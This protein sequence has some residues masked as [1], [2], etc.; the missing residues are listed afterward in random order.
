MVMIVVEDDQ[1]ESVLSAI[2]EAAF[3]NN[4]GDGKI[5]VTEVETAYT[6]RTGQAEL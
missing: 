5:F 6:V 1:V 3:T 2:Q 4:P